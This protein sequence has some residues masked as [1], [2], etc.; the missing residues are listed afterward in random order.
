MGKLGSATPSTTL[1]I[2]I[3]IGLCFFFP[4]YFWLFLIVGLIPLAINIVI[5]ISRK[6][7]LMSKYGNEEIVNKILNKVVWQGETSEQLFESLGSPQDIDEKVL[8]TKFKQIWKYNH[9]GSNRYG[10]RIIIENNIV[11]GWDNQ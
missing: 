7:V 10:L 5:K 9:R 6:R 4:N 2:L 3:I 11:V 1:F 8:K